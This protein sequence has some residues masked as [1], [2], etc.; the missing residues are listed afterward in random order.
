[1]PRSDIVPSDMSLL[2]LMAG[3]GLGA[4]VAGLAVLARSR[5]GA[6]ERAAEI[7]RLASDLAHF[8]EGAAE[9]ERLLAQAEERLKDAFKALSADALRQNAEQFLVAARETLG[10]QEAEA[11]GDLEKREAAIRGLVEPLAK[12]LEKMHENIQV[13]EKTRERAYGTLTE[14]LRALGQTEEALRLETGRLVNALKKPSVRGQWGEMQ[15][16]RVVEL[17]NM[18]DRVDFTE[19]VSVTNEDRRFRPDLIVHLP[20]GKD[21]VVDAKTPLEA[22]LAALETEDEAE[23]KRLLAGHA[24]QVRSHI[25]KLGQKAYWDQFDPTP[26]FVVMFL[27]AESIFSAALEEDPSLIEEGVK[28]KVILATP[29]TLIA[30]LRAVAYGWREEKLAENARHISELGAELYNRIRVLGEHVGKLGKSLGAAVES[31]NKSV[32]ALESRV[33]TQARRFRDLSVSCSEAIEEPKAIETSPRPLSAPELTD[34]KD[35]S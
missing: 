29:T 34:G 16:R 22:Y 25:Q 11:R 21:V 6:A 10:R 19:Q 1:M 35:E 31:Y 33:L 26:E 9:K 14:Q 28:Q 18:T 8:R 13:I 27:P 3:L 24:G 23:R 17:A 30:L 4:L 2:F 5:A 32:A 12:S 20:A 7:A 15:L